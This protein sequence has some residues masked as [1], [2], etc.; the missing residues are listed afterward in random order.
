MQALAV[1]FILEQALDVLDQFLGVFGCVVRWVDVCGLGIDLGKLGEV[2]VFLDFE[3]AEALDEGAGAV[4]C[5]GV[6]D[7]G[8][9]AAD[10]LQLALDGLALG[11]EFGVLLVDMAL[12]LGLAFCDGVGVED[13]VLKCLDD[14]LFE[15]FAG[16]GF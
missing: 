10:G 11:C 15:R 2:L 7:V 1:F 8:D 9:L 12:I 14:G 13:E 4:F 5:D 16:D 3:F 6:G